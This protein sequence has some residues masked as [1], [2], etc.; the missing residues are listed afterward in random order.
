MV[1]QADTLTCNE[2]IA[3]L[4]DHQAEL[5]A[6]G[7]EGLTL[8]GSIARNDAGPESDID[9]AVRLSDAFS[10]GG[11][12]YFGKLEQ[13]RI[14]LASLLG[15]DVDLVEMPARRPALQHAIER[16]GVRAF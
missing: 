12:D 16:D 14:T 9:L 5:Q 10:S 13:A 11:F 3:L 8:F 1:M 6:H 7:I 2:I 4:R 15:R